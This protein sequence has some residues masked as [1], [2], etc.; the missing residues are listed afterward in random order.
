MA[1]YG[2]EGKTREAFAVL[3]DILADERFLPRFGYELC[4]NPADLECFGGGAEEGYV[5]E[6]HQI[7]Y[8]HPSGADFFYR[9]GNLT[10]KHEGVLR[11]NMPEAHKKEIDKLAGPVIKLL[12]PAYQMST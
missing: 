12:C 7:K 10:G 8:T 2:L 5:R 9:F 11:I 1:E 4:L 6:I 3:W